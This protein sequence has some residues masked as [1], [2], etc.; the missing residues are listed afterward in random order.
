MSQIK[1]QIQS[2]LTL[3]P[4]CRRRCWHRHIAGN[5]TKLHEPLPSPARLVSP[6]RH[7]HLLDLSSEIASGVRD[8][9]HDVCW[10]VHNLT[11]TVIVVGEDE[12]LIEK[13]RDA[14]RSRRSRNCKT[15]LEGI[16]HLITTAAVTAAAAIAE[17]HNSDE[18][19]RKTSSSPHSKLHFVLVQSVVGIATTIALVRRQWCCFSDEVM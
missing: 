14:T 9:D 10:G 18:L 6:D 12:E 19:T 5:H 7:H 1:S 11:T 3:I 13:S 16:K 2:N 8:W 17:G 15:A 4:N